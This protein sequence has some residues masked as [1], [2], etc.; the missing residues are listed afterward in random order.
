MSKKTICILSSFLSMVLI[1]LCIGTIKVEAAAVAL[2]KTSCELTVGEKTTLKLSGTKAP[3]TWTS[4]KKGV[5]TVNKAGK[6]TAKKAGTTVIKAK[7][8]GKTYSCKVT[9]KNA[10]ANATNIKVTANGGGDFIVGISSLNIDFMLDNTSTA[11]KVSV[12]NAADT[13]VYAKTFNK[14]KKNTEKTLEWNGKDSKGNYVTEGT[15]YC[16]I[17]AG[18]T[19][20]KTNYFTLY[21]DNDF[22]G[23]NGSEQNPYQVSNAT[24]FANILKHNGKYFKQT[25]DIDFAYEEAPSLFTSDQMFTGKYDG[26]GKKISNFLSSNALFMYVGSEGELNNICI[27]DGTVNQSSAANGTGI[28]LL[29]KYNYGVISNCNVTGSAIGCDSVALLAAYNYYKINNCSSSGKVSATGNDV[30]SAAGLVANNYNEGKIIDS[31]YRCR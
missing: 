28:A 27:E 9:V 17:L 25:K 3:I 19:V 22:A 30:T 16:E 26:N 1:V 13:T 14:I 10:S 8:S 23:G 5:A 11:V 20:T 7:V 6:V 21:S 4:S 31:R 2:N 24:E 12:R 15:Y 29:A 18:S